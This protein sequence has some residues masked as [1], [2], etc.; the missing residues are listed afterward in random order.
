[1]PQLK[2]ATQAL[3][4]QN[5]NNTFA[6]SIL[7]TLG[8]SLKPVQSYSQVGSINSALAP[9]QKLGQE[10]IQQAMV[11]E[12]QQQTFNPFI[13]QFANRAAGSNL[14]LM[15]NSGNFVQ[16]RKR[17]VTQPFYNQVQ[18]VKDRFNRAAYDSADQ[19]LLDFYKSQ[20]NF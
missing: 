12:F 5:I 6:K 1:M 20:I 19:R 10:F 13:R 3:P 17:E 16:D 7:D 15:G 18:E 8:Q 11:P 14:S 2:G 9:T 4:K